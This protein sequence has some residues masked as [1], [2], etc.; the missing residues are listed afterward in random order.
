MN[1]N[2]YIAPELHRHHARNRSSS[3]SGSEDEEEYDGDGSNDDAS[4]SRQQQ[5]QQQQ[6]QQEG[7]VQDQQEHLLHSHKDDILLIVDDRMAS[8]VAAA[9]AAAA[10]PHDQD[11]QDAKPEVNVARMPPQETDTTAPEASADQSCQFCF[12]DGH[13]RNMQLEEAIQEMAHRYIEI[14]NSFRE[15]ALDVLIRQVRNRGGR[16]LTRRRNDRE[17]QEDTAGSSALAWVPVSEH[18]TRELLETIFKRSCYNHQILNDSAVRRLQDNEH[19]STHKKKRSLPSSSSSSSSTQRQNQSFHI[20]AKR[21][22]KTQNTTHMVVDLATI[23]RDS[24][25][26]FGKDLSMNQDLT[27]IHMITS[28]LSMADANAVATGLKKCK[29]LQQIKLQFPNQ[30][31][32]QHVFDGHLTLLLEGIF[33]NPAV[34]SINLNDNGINSKICEFIC[35]LFVEIPKNRIARICFENNPIGDD[36]ALSLAKAIQESPSL[37]YISLGKNGFTRRGIHVL[38]RASTRSEGRLV[39]ISGV[40]AVEHYQ[41]HQE[42]G[43]SRDVRM[44]KSSSDKYKRTTTIVSEDLTTSNDDSRTQSGSASGSNCGTSSNDEED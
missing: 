1:P 26:S 27:S 44:Y 17:H 31:Q 35:N 43:P 34:Q 23:R 2:N 37:R 10:F 6:R 39:E 19:K 8:Q 9:A 41:H 25:F 24:L 12:L 32:E 11:P 16:F 15:S 42:S 28:S 7:E 14:K 36:G 5:Q 40:Q 38:Q 22:K 33:E 4:T 30:Q 18:Q 20:G 3:S 13:S 21:H 29:N